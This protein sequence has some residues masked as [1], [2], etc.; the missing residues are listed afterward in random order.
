MPNKSSNNHGTH[1]NSKKLKGCDNSD[2]HELKKSQLKINRPTTF[3]DVKNSNSS[4]SDATNKK[5]IDE[6]DE[7]SGVDL[8][9]FLPSDQDDN[10]S[11]SSGKQDLSL[12]M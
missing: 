9:P 6:D 3:H 11:S 12:S 8:G 1:S 10:T 4:M 2:N 5:S 7:D